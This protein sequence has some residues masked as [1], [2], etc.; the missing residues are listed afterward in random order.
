MVL[1]SNESQLS[2]LPKGRQKLA[3]KSI[4][5]YRVTKVD[6]AT[7]NYTLDIPDSRRHATFHISNIQRYVDPRL[8]LFPNRQRR[9]PRISE[10]KVDQNLEVQK[11][12]GH[13][14]RRDG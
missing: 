2:H 4:A 13:E 1:V 11:I 8:E 9:Q 14:R 12:I 10:S 6:K 7:S 3:L 5:P